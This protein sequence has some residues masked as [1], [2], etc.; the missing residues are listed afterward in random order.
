M[1]NRRFAHQQKEK[2]EI[3]IPL[4]KFT[5]IFLLS[6]GSLT[7]QEI[8]QEIPIY[9]T[10]FAGELVTNNNNQILSQM[11]I[12]QNQSSCQSQ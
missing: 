4:C 3:K 12:L 6:P 5:C 7:D 9:W 8:H 10:P 11:D 1:R 2:L